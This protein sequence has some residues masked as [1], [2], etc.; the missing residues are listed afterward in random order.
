M[1]NVL[2]TKQDTMSRASC[3]AANPSADDLAALTGGGGC[4]SNVS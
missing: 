3:A 4:V 1:F 2:R